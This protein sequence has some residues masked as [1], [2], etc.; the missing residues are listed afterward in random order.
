MQQSGVQL[1]RGRFNAT[2]RAGGVLALIFYSVCSANALENHSIE[3]ARLAFDELRL[4]DASRALDANEIENGPS[5]MVFYLKSRIA[6]VQGKLDVARKVADACLDQF[7]QEAICHEASGETDL[8]GLVLQGGILKKIG[9]ARNAR[10]ALEQAVEL[11][12]QNVRARLL[13]VRFYTLAPWILGGSKSKARQQVA[14]CNSQNPAVGHEAQALYDLAAGD[15]EAAVKGFA[16]AQRLR[17]T[18][19]DPALFLAQAYLANDQPV[20]A[21][22][23]L[24]RLITR[25]PRFQEAWLELGKIAAEKGLQSVR[26]RAALEYF[27]ANSKDDVSGRR[28]EAAVALARLHLQADQTAAAIDVL[29]RVNVE[30]PDNRPARKLL[31]RICRASPDNCLK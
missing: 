17:P 3:Q 29:E 16:E 10:K 6:V 5:A 30:A 28:L 12:N 31:R 19:R 15:T 2:L 13:L 21:M 26:G 23:T 8:I 24:E 22:E 18:E 14:W 20:A 9:A 25:Y 1:L 7:A 27:L 4:A 11:D